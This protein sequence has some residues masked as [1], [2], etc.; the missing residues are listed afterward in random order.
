MD[1]A[2]MIDYRDDAGN[3]YRKTVDDFEFC[4]HEED[5]YFISSGTKYHIPLDQVIQVFLN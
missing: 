4:V 5:V 3:I 1:K 2:L